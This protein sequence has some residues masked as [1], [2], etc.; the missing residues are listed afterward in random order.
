MI[1]ARTRT[2]KNAPRSAANLGNEDALRQAPTRVSPVFTAS[3]GRLLLTPAHRSA[4]SP[5]FTQHA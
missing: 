5:D 3:L 4:K 2:A 1:Y